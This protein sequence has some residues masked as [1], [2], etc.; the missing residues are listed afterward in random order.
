[1]NQFS[2]FNLSPALKTRL[3][4][5]NFV[6][7]TPVQAGAIPPALEG[8]DVLATAQTGTGKTLS[9]LIPII[10]R[11]PQSANK[12]SK[13]LIL[14]PTRELAMQV[15]Q[16]FRKISAG[17]NLQVA[18]VC[19]GMNEGPQLQSIRKGARLIVATPGRLEDYLK[20]KLVRLDQVEMLVLDEVDRML[21]MGFQPAIRR[22]S[23]AIPAKR[24][25]LCYSATLD[26]QIKNVV[27]DY[28][29]DPVR[30][31]IGS[32]LKPSENV[33]LQSFE[34]EQEKKLE[35]LE[36]L[37]Q[38]EKGSFLVFVRTKH[39]A[40]RVAKK[41]CRSGW[42]ATQIHGDRSQSQR[43]AALRSFAE[44][45]HRVLVATD[46]AARGIDVSH[47]AHVVNYDI[48]KVAEDFVH[49]VGRTGRA[50]SHGVASTFAAPNERRD[51]R[52]IEK[53][54]S[55][56]MKRFRVKGM[57]PSMGSRQAVQA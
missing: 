50:S 15:E 1:M 20:R 25:T 42:G 32:V 31:E 14:L 38:S 23:D 5:A 52:R 53:T 9:F 18:L 51:L 39:G 57:A 36:H 56:Q 35:L 24:Q 3:A 54:L 7:P 11:L 30:I 19:G 8:K 12:N 16:A 41:L 48:P 55:I 13:A 4:A 47:V 21:D 45:K 43:N 10:E 46:V 6:T 26:A 37:L 2:D 33:E 27:R 29:K 44:G 28:L 34:V 40:D 22:I 17:S 49:R